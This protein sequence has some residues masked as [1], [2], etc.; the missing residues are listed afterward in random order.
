MAVASIKNTGAMVPEND[1][2]CFVGLT[3]LEIN[4]PQF[5]ALVF[6]QIRILGYSSLKS[7]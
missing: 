6:L 2:F 5:L 7:K 1:V 3:V 4:P